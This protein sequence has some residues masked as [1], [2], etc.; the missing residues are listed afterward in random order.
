MHACAPR[1]LDG[2]YLY[3]GASETIPKALALSDGQS[4]NEVKV[5]YL[6]VLAWFI[7]GAILVGLILLDHEHCEGEAEEGGGGH[8]HGH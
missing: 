6:N 7:I 3:L 1:R 8:A 4:F 2:T 5:H